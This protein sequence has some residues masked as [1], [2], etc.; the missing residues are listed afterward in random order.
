[1][2]GYQI[3][4]DALEGTGLYSTGYMNNNLVILAPFALIAVALVIW[5]QRAINKSLVEEH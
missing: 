1:M 2:A 3:F 5:V 4:G